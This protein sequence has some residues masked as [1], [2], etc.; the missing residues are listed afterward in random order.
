M[1]QKRPLGHYIHTH[2]RVLKYIKFLIIDPLCLNADRHRWCAGVSPACG[3]TVAEG[4]RATGSVL[5]RQF[6][7]TEVL[8]G[9]RRGAKRDTEPVG[10]D[11]GCDAPLTFTPQLTRLVYKGVSLFKSQ[12]MIDG[13]GSDG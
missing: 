13:R 12:Y 1:F 9:G 10:N 2:Y 5:V 11:T 3:E 8:G 6:A 7:L 4:I